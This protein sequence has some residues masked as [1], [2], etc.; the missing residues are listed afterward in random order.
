MQ[1]QEIN[2]IPLDGPRPLQEVLQKYK[3]ITDINR[4][5]DMEI[6][7]SVEVNGKIVSI[8]RRLRAK[9]VHYIINQN[10]AL[11][12]A[13]WI[14]RALGLFLNSMRPELPADVRCSQLV[15]TVLAVDTEIG[16]MI[17]NDFLVQRRS[18]GAMS[19]SQAHEMVPEDCLMISART[20]RALCAFNRGW[21]NT[22]WLMVVRYPNLGPGTT[23]K[24]RLLVND[25][26]PRKDAP[27]PDFKPNQLGARLPMLADLLR[28][29][30]ELEEEEAATVGLVDCFYLNPKTLKD[31][32]EGDGDGDLIYCARVGRGRPLFKNLNLVR[33]P[34]EPDAEVLAKLKSKARRTERGK[35]D[36]YLP[37]YFDSGLLIA[38]ATY[39][40]HW[41]FFGDRLDEPVG[42]EAMQ[43]AWDRIGPK[44]IGR[45]EFIFDMRKGDHDPDA[46]DRVVM[47]LAQIS[48]T[49]KQAQKNNVWF[50]K[51]V[52]TSQVQDIPG[53]LTAFPTLQQLANYITH[54]NIV[55]FEQLS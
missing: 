21:I 45:M 14:S 44:S 35:L 22:Q 43:R 46:V 18:P 10:G 42:P 13:C 54:N 50:A 11:I 1:Q 16:S 28:D 8:P 25:N 24:L 52:P 29:M 38:Q 12:K 39:A 53:L 41:E 51:I 4:I 19:F 36:T 33:E 15:N 40:T 34:G 31:S 2:S 17:K 47:E 26:P 32:F 48:K 5:V 55:G 27:T 7:D 49:I 23:R 6:P 3:I 20:Y 9:D 30:D 37:K